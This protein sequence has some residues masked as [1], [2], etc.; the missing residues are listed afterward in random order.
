MNQPVKALHPNVILHIDIDYFYAQVEE[1]LN[2]ELKNKPFGIQQG[3]NI[4]TCNYKAREFGIKK[5]RSL[6]ECLEK[7]PDLVI[8]NGEDLSSYKVYSKKLSDLLHN[9][10]GPTER[11]GLDEHYIDITK[12]VEEEMMSKTSEEIENLHLTGPFHPSEDAF[13]ECDCKCERR[14]M[15]GSQIAS[16]LREKVLEDLKLTCSVGIAHNKLL[17]K[18]VG[19][20]NKPDNQTT[21]APLSSVEFM[22]ELKDLR[23]IHGIGSR[24]A[25]R[26]EELGIKTIEDLQ[27]CEIEK[28]KENFGA[29]MATRLKQLSVGCDLHEVKP[30]GKPKTVGLEDS[31]RPISL[32]ADAEVMFRDLLPRLVTQIRDDGRIPQGLRVTVRK[33]DVAK[34]TSSRETKQLSLSASQFRFV[35][36]AIQFVGDAE[37]KILKNVITTFDLITGANKKFLVNLIGLCFNKFQEQKSGHGSITS[38]MVKGKGELTKKEQIPAID[39]EAH[40]STISIDYAKDGSFKS[41]VDETT[42]P[43]PPKRLKLDEPSSTELPANIDPTVWNELPLDLQQELMRSWLP[44][45]RNENY[46]EPLVRQ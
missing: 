32:R 2:P 9:F 28:L 20:M 16:K 41:I 15:I 3:A 14:L 39:D 27:N 7:C 4:V 37:E 46:K 40:G 11:V 23:S 36:G 10:L 26:I 33:Y 5:W 12:K 35:E 29:E 30:S 21:L 43:P 8:V 42:E 34:K 13:T 25:E 38:F 22:L 19:Q 18:L 24:T 31:C 6:K 45:Q 44:V 1:L 17:A